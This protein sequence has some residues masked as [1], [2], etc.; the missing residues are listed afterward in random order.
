MSGQTRK[1][2]LENLGNKR[3]GNKEKG[4]SDNNVDSDVCDV[5]V[6]NDDNNTN[7]NDNAFADPGDVL[8]DLLCDLKQKAPE[9]GSQS[10]NYENSGDNYE[11]LFDFA[12]GGGD[13][14][15]DKQQLKVA[16]GEEDSF[17]DVSDTEVDWMILTPEEKAAKARMW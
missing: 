2:N 5:D 12:G 16:E 17:L 9:L 13:A 10:N 4:S 14:Q 6:A 7:S 11:D 1:E 8:R 3:E 15:T